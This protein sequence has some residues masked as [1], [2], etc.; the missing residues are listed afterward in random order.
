VKAK[1]A[2]KMPACFFLRLDCGWKTLVE[3]TCPKEKQAGFATGLF[4]I[5]N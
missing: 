4:Q 2:G 1:Q 3:T 5:N